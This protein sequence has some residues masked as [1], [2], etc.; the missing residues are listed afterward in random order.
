MGVQSIYH[1]L[2]HYLSTV[3]TSHHHHQPNSPTEPSNHI[4]MSSRHV[5]AFSNIRFHLLSDIVVTFATSHWLS[6]PL[7]AEVPQNTDTRKEGRLYSQS[8]RKK[9]RQKEEPW[10]YCDKPKEGKHS[11]NC[12]NHF[13]NPNPRVKLLES[14]EH[15]Q[16]TLRYPQTY[17]STWC[18]TCWWHE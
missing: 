10:S 2:Q 9:R 14:Q 7:K 12:I 18:N 4:S 15:V 11:S 13:T 16:A 5:K 3:F 8:T 6:S 1:I 17:I